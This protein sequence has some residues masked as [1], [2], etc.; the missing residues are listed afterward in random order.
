MREIYSKY[1]IDEL[2][3]IYSVKS[4]NFIKMKL[5]KSSHG[6]I[7]VRLMIDKKPK[8]KYIHRLLAENYIENKQ[9]K[10][11][12]NHINGIKTDNRLINL[13]WVTYSENNKHAFDNNLK[14]PSVIKSRFKSVIVTSLDGFI[15]GVFENI[16][17]CANF[18]N[19][20]ERRIGEYILNKKKHNKYLF[21]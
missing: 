12:V 18:L 7:C 11:C 21:L 2:G 5:Y 17:S 16:R 8:I 19:I 14:K 9:N 4:G 6:Y 15:I 10:P 20:N 3:N 1:Y 13:E